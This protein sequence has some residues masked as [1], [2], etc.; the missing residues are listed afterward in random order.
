MLKNFIKITLRNILRQKGFSFINIF[1]LAIGMAVVILIALFIR[2]ELSYDKFHEKYDRI[3]RL[4]SD[5]PADKDSFAGT[6]APLGPAMKENFPD[7]VDYVRL[8]DTSGV[9][10]YKD[11]VFYED[12]IL[13]ADNSIFA[14]FTFPLIKGDPQTALENKDSIVITQ[15]MAKKYFPG[16]EPMGKILNLND[17]ADLKITGVTADVPVNS[18]FHFDFIIP[19]KR[20]RNLDSWGAWNYFTYLLMHESISPGR[21]KEKFENWA[22]QFDNKNYFSS[23]SFKHIYYQ[24][25]TRIHFQYNRKNMEPAFDGNY[26]RVFGAIALVILIL[27][28]INFMNLSTARASGRAKE[29]GI[30][31]VVGASQLKLIKQFI[32]ESLLL[33]FIAHMI[34]V[35][36]VRLVLPVFNN[37]SARNLSIDYSDPV[38]VLGI[39]GLILFT[40]VLSGCYPAFVLSSFKVTNVL[41]SQTDGGTRS[42]ARDILVV[43]QFTIAIVL[44]IGTIIIFRQLNFLRNTNLGFNMKDVI[45]I[46]LRSRD[47]ME[48]ASIL[49]KEFLQVPGVES[50]SANGYLPTSMNWHQSVW[51]EG[52]QESERAS[53]WVI[54][55]DRDFMDTLQIKMIEGK[56]Y[57]KKFSS[58]GDNAHAYVLNES[59]VKH[60][61]WKSALG[62]AFSIYGQEM[63]GPIVGV[64][65]D[66]HFRSLHHRIDPCAMIVL[67]EYGSC[68]SLRIN[69]P[70]PKATIN[71]LKNKWKELVPNLEF[72]Y[73]FLED[74]YNKLYRA[75][76]KSGQLIIYF[77]LLCIFIACLGLFGLASFLARQKTKEIGIRKVFGASVSI[78]TRS[79]TGKFVRLVILANLLSWPIAYF[80]LNNWLQNFAYR[81]DI[82]IW[83]FL[84]AAVLSFMIS[85]FTVSYQSIKAAMTNPIDTLRYE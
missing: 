74:N 43:F 28:C 16:E 65:E 26:I 40:G 66:F 79:L 49:K 23:L 80:V 5:N 59:A 67:N 2:N 51:W 73:Y 45:N 75:E 21:L 25:I 64:T 17:R 22:K 32:G 61:G 30:K 42:L 55:I 1:G 8:I 27:A 15:S 68:M 18:H 82:N 29:I 62:N 53:M 13:M 77:T 35:I 71:A 54:S 48:K 52:K 4:I 38:F 58:G 7:I 36:L 39:L 6:P 9:F 72:D 69:T 14:V 44:M 63:R 76:I 20:L 47:L 46:P 11:K 81:I 84:L 37:F 10:K 70:H 83:A 33:A 3:F 56:D 78:I 60:I 50:A 12:R 57:V 85:M 24:P 19:F 34:A 41:K 31:K